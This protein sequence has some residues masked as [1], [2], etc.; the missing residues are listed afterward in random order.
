[1]ALGRCTDGVTGWTAGRAENLREIRF[2]EV[3]MNRLWSGLLG[4][5]LGGLVLLLGASAA[6]AQKDTLVIA[7][8]QDP[9]IIDPTLS[10]T[11]VGRIIYANMCEKLYDID[12]KL[13]IF[14]Q[15]A[16]E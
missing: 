10:R 9:D 1:M 5:L 15:L 8:N 6:W 3:A 4:A 7:L 13:N 12:E 11:Y 16:A 2:G 14:P